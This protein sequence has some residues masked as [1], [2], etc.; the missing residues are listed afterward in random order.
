MLCVN[1]L[2]RFPQPIELNLQAWNGYTPI[3][4][5][6]QVSFPRIG[7]LPYLLTL[8]GHGFYWFQLR[9]DSRAHPSEDHGG[10]TMNLP[11]ADWLPHQRWYAGRGRTL[12]CRRSGRGDRPLRDNLE[13]VLLEASYDDG[14]RALSGL[15][16]ART[17]SRRRN[18]AVAATIGMDGDRV[19]IDA[20]YDRAGR[21]V[22]LSRSSTATR[23]STGVR[24]SRSRT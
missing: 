16:R 20:L 23:P 4:L 13:H 3:E 14:R 15:R 8:P 11:F 17:P 6:G 7:Q 19:G 1:N 10:I 22:L 21:P 5:T 9:R 18:T 12:A 2:S 24:F